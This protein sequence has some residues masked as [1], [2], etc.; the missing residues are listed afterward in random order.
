MGWIERTDV[1]HSCRLPALEVW[2]VGSPPARVHV[3][4][5]GDR[6]QCDTC[7]QV[8]GVRL[9]QNS[10]GGYTYVDGLKWLKESPKKEKRRL[11]GGPNAVD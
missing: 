1:S 6:W 11:F 5:P 4:Q 2:G 3:A 8:W 7:G 9:F 10:L